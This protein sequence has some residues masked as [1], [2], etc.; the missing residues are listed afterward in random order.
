[1]ERAGGTDDAV[2]FSFG[3]AGILRRL[4]EN[5]EAERRG[6]AAAREADHA[7]CAG[8]FC[9]DLFMESAGDE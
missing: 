1:M 8:D 4:R 3:G 6:H 7:I 9:G 5:F 2:G